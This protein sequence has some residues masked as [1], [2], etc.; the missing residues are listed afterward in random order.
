VSG[1]ADETPMALDPQL[2]R[3]ASR[4]ADE[5]RQDLADPAEE[6]QV[7]IIGVVDGFHVRQASLLRPRDL[8]RVVAVLLAVPDE[9]LGPDVL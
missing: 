5:L 6:D 3:E 2:G 7:A 4:G 1:R 9:H 8:K